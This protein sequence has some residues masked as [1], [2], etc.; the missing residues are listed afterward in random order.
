[1]CANGAAAPLP[2]PRVSTEQQFQ[3]AL[4]AQSAREYRAMLLWLR[5]AATAGD[6]Q[7]QEMLG[8]ALLVGPT[9]YGPAIKADRCE[10]GHWLA[11]ASAQGSEAARVS[12]DFLNR[13]R[14]A[15]SGQDVCQAWRGVPA[16]Y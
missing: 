14:L 5:R 16:P 1:M 3:L 13:L 10:A 6:V 15:P 4:E 11:R 2:A 9:L 8:L 7:A 12:L